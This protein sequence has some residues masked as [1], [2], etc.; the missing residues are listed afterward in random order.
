MHFSMAASRCGVTCA[1][2]GAAKAATESTRRITGIALSIRMIGLPFL[3]MHILGSCVRGAARIGSRIE[4][5]NRALLYSGAESD[6]RAGWIREE[7]TRAE[8]AANRD[9]EDA[10]IVC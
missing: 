5:N 6:D 2:A 3:S 1:D 9:E 10:S 7:T 8:R 4:Q